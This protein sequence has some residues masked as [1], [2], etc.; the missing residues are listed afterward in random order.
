[1]NIV[2]RLTHDMTQSRRQKTDLEPSTR[3]RRRRFNIL[4]KHTCMTWCQQCDDDININTLVLLAGLLDCWMPA[5]GHSHLRTVWI[6]SSQTSSDS[7]LRQDMLLSPM[8]AASNLLKLSA[9]FSI[10]F[11]LECEACLNKTRCLPK[12][13]EFLKHSYS[14]S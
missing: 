12:I 8:L 1:M 14:Y 10:I 2:N 11:F 4:H 3:L 7:G 5:W 6:L 9:F 13:Y